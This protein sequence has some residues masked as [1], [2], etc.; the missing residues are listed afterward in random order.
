MLQRATT[1]QNVRASQMPSKVASTD[2]FKVFRSNLTEAMDEKDPA[3]AVMKLCQK[4]N[5]RFRKQ[6]DSMT[7]LRR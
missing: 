4:E 5:M 2:R 6:F 7:T 1:S 3:K